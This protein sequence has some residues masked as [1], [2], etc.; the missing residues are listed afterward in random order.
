MLPPRS[1]MARQTWNP[2]QPGMSRSQTTAS[3]WCS[4]TS[5][6][7]PSPSPASST[8]QPATVSHLPINL[9]KLA[10]SSMTRIVF[11]WRRCRMFSFLPGKNKHLTGKSAL[12]FT[13]VPFTVFPV[14]WWKILL[15][16][17]VAAFAFDAE[18][19]GAR[20]I[21]VL[22]HL[23]DRDSRHTLSPSLYERDAYQSFLR[24]NADQCAGLRFDVQWKAK[25]TD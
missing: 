1:R 14:R 4:L 9:R 2:L 12:S 8:F 17:T 24:K 20:I 15:M 3:G 25:A 23:L 21:K 10:S 22:P 5:W 6:M 7:P 16:V 18:A 13:P 11:I 19:A